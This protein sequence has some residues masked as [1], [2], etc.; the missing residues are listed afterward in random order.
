[1]GSFDDLRRWEQWLFD[2]L[3][4]FLVLFYSY[5][6]VLEPMDTQYHRGIYV[7]IT[8]VLVFLLYQSRSTI[9]RV[10]DYLLILSSL[11][12]LGYW[13]YVFEIINYRV[14]AET[15]LDQAIAIV[16]VLLGMEVARRVVGNVFIIIG[17][18]M[19]LYGVFGDYMPGKFSHAGH[20]R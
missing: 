17:T 1:M 19:L 4:L 12:T 15:E 14:G 13:I 11:V 5:A 6:A 8:Y 10:A 2:A 3:A 18:I 16:G 20:W 9:G 7:V